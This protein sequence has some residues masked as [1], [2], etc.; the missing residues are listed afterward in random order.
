MKLNRSSTA[1]HVVA[2]VGGFLLFLFILLA[3]YELAVRFVPW[4]DPPPGVIYDCAP[5]RSLLQMFDLAIED[6]SNAAFLYE[7]MILMIKTPII[8]IALGAFCALLFALVRFS[9]SFRSFNLVPRY[10]LLFFLVTC[11]AVFVQ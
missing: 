5:P 11:L 9:K 1:Q 10:V 8:L 6:P 2:A 4:C 3:S 7:E